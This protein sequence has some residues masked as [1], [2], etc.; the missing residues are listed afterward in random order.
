[1][2]AAAAGADIILVSTTEDAGAIAYEAMLAGAR[3]GTIPR[4]TVIDADERIL[5]LKQRYAGGQTR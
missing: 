5:R 1:V 2:R 3:D 4:A